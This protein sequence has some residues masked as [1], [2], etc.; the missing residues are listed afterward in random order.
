M[1]GD[2]VTY[3]GTTWKVLAVFGPEHG[4]HNGRALIRSVEPAI[5]P[6]HPLMRT[7]EPTNHRK[8]LWREVKVTELTQHEVAP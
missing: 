8:T 5:K 3:N 7:P 2:I 4:I 6:Y 1:K